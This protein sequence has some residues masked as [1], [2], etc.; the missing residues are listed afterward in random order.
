M[1]PAG[2]VRRGNPRRRGGARHG[3]RRQHQVLR[4]QTDYPASD[5]FVTAA[6]GTTTAIG[7][8]GKLAWQT[9]WG[10]QKYSLSADGT[11]RTSVGFL[12]GAGGGYSALFDRPDYQIGVV[13]GN[14]PAGRA[15]PD[16]ALDADPTTG[17]LVGETQTVPKGG[18]V[19]YAEYRIGGTS[20]AAP[21]FSGMTALTLQHAGGGI[22]LLNPTIYSQADSGTFTDVKGVPADAG[23]VR[24]DFV[25]S[26]DASGGVVY[27]VR[28]F[29]QDSSLTIGAG[30][31]DIT[32]VGS[33][34]AGWLTSVSG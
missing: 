31:D 13:P 8:D 19:A 11:S 32:G 1:W 6:G 17:M 27:S 28:T 24:P 15:V 22:G 29:N 12:Y 20:L 34:N 5:P 21:L 10:T 25:N 33:P 3:G 14:A 16:V 23:N 7:A 9:G 4:S 18:G 30:W 26:V 2:L